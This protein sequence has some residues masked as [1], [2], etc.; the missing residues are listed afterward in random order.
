MLSVNNDILN[1]I[2]T[3]TDNKYGIN[4]ELNDSNNEI[5]SNIHRTSSPELIDDITLINNNNSNNN[6]NKIRPYVPLSASGIE[7]KK[8]N[9]K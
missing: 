4:D 9:Q 5:I 7:F 3:P 8:R 2:L 6:N 1:Q